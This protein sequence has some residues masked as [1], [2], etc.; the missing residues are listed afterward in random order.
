M[1]LYTSGTTGKP[2]GA[3]LS[4]RNLDQNSEIASRTTLLVGPDDVVLGALPLFHTFGQTVGMN[5]SIRVGA[6]PHP[7]PQIRPRRGAGDD[8]ARRRHPL[9]RGADDVRRAAPPPRAASSFDTSTLRLCMTGGAS[10]PVEVLRG[11]EEAFGTELMEGY[12][13]SETSP[14]ACSG[15]P[16]Q[17]RKP[18][19]IGTPIEGVEMRIVDEGRRGAA[20]RGRRDPDPR[21]QHHEGLLDAPGRDRRGDRAAAGSTAATSAAT[22]R[23]A[24]SSSST[25]KGHDHPRRLQRLSARG[26]GAA[27]RAPGDPR[28]R[29]PRRP[30]PRVGRGDR[31]R[32][33]P[34]PGAE[35]A[36]EEISAWVRER[37]AAYNTP[38]WSGSWTSCRKARPAR[39]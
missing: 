25:A 34:R 16:G 22:T 4:H 26:R 17:V 29:R 36:P 38:A 2:K 35:L 18:G 30:P 5:A 39:S 24:T 8:G 32:R 6:V 19:S 37:I 23:T 27:L 31:R 11:F 28:S 10:M 12:G 3:E 33:G 15:H 14:V 21:P 1:I 7:G 9:L 13:L 20:G